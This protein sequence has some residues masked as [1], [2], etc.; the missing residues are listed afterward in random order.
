MSQLHSMYL[1]NAASAIKENLLS[2]RIFQISLSLP[3]I[4]TPYNSIIL[5]AV[6]ANKIL[7]ILQSQIKFKKIKFI[8]LLKY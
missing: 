7:K 5:N 3:Q 6:K 2:S 1:K 8:Y 4:N